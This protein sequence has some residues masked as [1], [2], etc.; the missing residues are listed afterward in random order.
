MNQ[1]IL[2]HYLETGTYT[3]AGPYADYFKS[4]PD[5]IAE[6]GNLVS[7]QIIHRITL[8]EGN[9]NANKDLRYGDMNR[10]PWYRLRCEDDILLT[11]ITMTSELFRM[12]SRGFVSD[13]AVENKIV[14][15]CRY[16]SV[17]MSAI[18]K[19]KGI[20]TRCRAGFAPYFNKEKSMD[21]W[22]NQAWN[23]EKWILFD[24]DG[25]YD[26]DEMGFDQYNMEEKH[27]DWAAPAWLEIR[28]GETDGKRLVYADGMG[29]CSLK[30]VI[31]Y[32]MYD[33]H[34][35]MN[36]EITF[37]FMPTFVD[38]KFEKLTDKQ[39]EDL[40]NLA[41]LMCHPD[42]NFEELKRIWNTK[43]EYRILNSPLVGDWDNSFINQM[44]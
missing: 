26:K 13:R 8:R 42:E 24:A 14:V 4:L 22:I 12:D 10:Y 40:D 38:N 16:V 36:N 19:A 30:A 31:R 33:F 9:T 15:C 17:L 37:S 29:T 27:F 11:A 39:L 35:L 3:Y 1:S 43:K 7:S 25:F 34:A 6:L 23:G 2:N 44:Q 41:E 20:P 5:D 18:L 21:H 28:R 32:L